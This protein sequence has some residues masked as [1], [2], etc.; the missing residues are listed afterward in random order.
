MQQTLDQFK[1]EFK[2]SGN[3]W[4]DSGII[5]LFRAFNSAEN[6]ELAEKLGIRIKE[7]KFTVEGPNQDIVASFI[8]ETV[9]NL[10]NSEYITPTQNKDIW[11][12]EKEGEFKLYQKT[13]FTPFHAALISVIP[14]IKEKLFLK[15]MSLN[16]QEKL[17]TQ[18][19]SFNKSTDQKAKI[20]PKQAKNPE[21]AYVP[22]EIPKLSINTTLDLEPG[23]NCC[24]FCGRPV[25]KGIYP[26]GINY[27]WI[28]SATKLKNF[29]S[30][31]KGKLVMCG[32]C[33]A[34]SIAAY[35]IVRYHLNDKH[36]F[37]AL[38]HAESLSELRGIW[39]DIIAYSSTKGTENIY[40]NFTQDKIPAYHLS[41]NFVYL[42]ISMYN[43][44]RNN[45]SQRELKD[46]S[47]WKR[48]ASKRWYLS[49]GVNEQALQFRKELEFA[50]FG[51]LFRFFDFVTAG[52]EGVDLYQFFN[53]LFVERK[54]GYSIANVIHRD[55]IAEKL[56][57]FDDI[58]N[59]VERFTFEKNR[60]VKG[61][62]YFVKIY[63]TQSINEGIRME[64]QIVEICEHIGNRIGKY[65]YF[66]N[67]KGVLFGLRNSKNLKEFLENLNSAQFKMPTEKYSGRLAVPKEFLLKI[68]E[69]NWRQYKSLIT[70]FAKNPPAKKENE[71]ENEVKE[72]SK[73]EGENTA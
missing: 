5:S 46:D 52:E 16:L 6:K 12:D 51:D 54:K 2:E 22:M 32:Y 9:D 63:M 60:P 17:A 55:K 53:D 18:L 66:T 25:K 19:E 4:I 40:C 68:D 70:I 48:F 49:L 69:K 7:R 37:M 27:P 39:S 67:D 73:P 20:G 72:V 65:S 15:D 38:P 41:E 24:S 30:M 36:L 21:K 58:T 35:D 23:K 43:S 64:E 33:E 13:N 57:R 11:Y 59:E 3:Y 34:A 14:S 56:L 26:S 62:H 31:H 47:A 28:T 44:I 42:A 29:N 61:L 50:R 71:N 1:A 10:I 45:I 8:K